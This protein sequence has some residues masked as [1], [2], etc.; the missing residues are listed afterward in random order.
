MGDA[1]QYVFDANAFVWATNKDHSNAIDQH[2]RV[3]FNWLLSFLIYSVIA[4]MLLVILIGVPLLWL[5]GVLHL[6]FTILGA[7]RANEGRLWAYPL[8]IN[9][10]RVT[11]YR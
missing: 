4:V 3:I 2:G 1:T 5:L 9:F 10:F 8:S 11:D 7:V 6:V